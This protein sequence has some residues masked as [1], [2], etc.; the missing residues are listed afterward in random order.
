MK[1]IS[2]FILFLLAS[3]DSSHH[4]QYKKPFLIVG[5]E[6]FVGHDTYYYQDANGE[7]G[8]FEFNGK[9]YNLGDSIR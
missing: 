7:W 4:K 2:I 5:R 1:Y 6:K 9:V 8:S 3:C